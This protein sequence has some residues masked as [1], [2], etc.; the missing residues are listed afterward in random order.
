MITLC[1][2]EYFK[3]SQ[4]SLAVWDAI[5]EPFGLLDGKCPETK[6]IC[7]IAWLVYCSM[8][9]YGSRPVTY[10]LD[11]SLGNGILM[12]GT[13]AGE[14]LLLILFGTISPESFSIVDT[15]VKTNSKLIILE[16][17]TLN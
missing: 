9:H 4:A 1:L 7:F 15:A 10:C 8:N 12:F 3:R 5:V 16:G 17:S 13:N 11:I 14:G 6:I 2:G